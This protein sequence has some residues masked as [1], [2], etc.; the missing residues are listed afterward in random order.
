MTIFKLTFK[1]DIQRNFDKKFL[2]ECF[3]TKYYDAHE[4]R[5][6]LLMIQTMNAND[7]SKLYTVG[8]FVKQDNMY[9]IFYIPII[10]NNNI[11]I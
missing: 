8:R 10:E 1:N 9:W 11:I 4:F 2:Y 5:N 7:T 6:S 3:L